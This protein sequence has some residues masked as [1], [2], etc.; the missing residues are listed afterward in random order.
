MGPSA[1]ASML[2]SN[3]MSWQLSKTDLQL[4][5]SLCLA[6]RSSWVRTQLFPHQ[7]QLSSSTTKQTLLSYHRVQYSLWVMPQHWASGISPGTVK[8]W[9]LPGWYRPL[10]SSLAKVQQSYWVLNTALLSWC[11]RLLLCRQCGQVLYGSRTALSFALPLFWESGLQGLRDCASGHAALA[12]LHWAVLWESSIVPWE[13][14][15]LA[16]MCISLQFKGA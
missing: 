7:I 5:L 2:K 9:G 11:C 8:I 15:S 12:L 4:L 13:C 6:L 10:Y 16:Y 14:A 3:R 1:A